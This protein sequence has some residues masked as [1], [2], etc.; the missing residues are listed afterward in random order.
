MEL[1][2]PKEIVAELDKYI[3]G[4]D[5]AKKAVAVALRNRYRRSQLPESLREDI[6]PKNIL[7]KG[8]TGVGKTEIAR[9]LA[10]IVRAPF[11]KVEATKYTE[12]GYVGR[13]VES[14]IRD[15]VETSI[16]LVR[17]EK[18]EQVKATAT[19]NANKKIRDLLFKNNKAR[20]KAKATTSTEKL[21]ENTIEIVVEDAESQNKADELLREVEQGKHDQEYVEVEVIETSKMIEIIPGAP[22]SN[23]SDM[24]DG[25]LPKRKKLRKITV[26]QARRNFVN[27]ESDRLI[28]LDAVNEEGVRR[29]E[30]EGIIFI[31]EIDKIAISRGNGSGPDVSR[32]GV[33]RDILPFVEGCTVNTKYGLIKTD[34]ILFIAAGAFHIAKMDDLIPELQGRFPIRVELENL[35][36]KDFYNILTQPK[37]AITMQ[38]TELLRVDNIDLKFDKDAL[39]EIAKIAELE[40][41]NQENI[42]ARRLHTIMEALLN[43]ISFEAD[44]SYPMSKVVITKDMVQKVLA[45]SVK[46]YDIT[47]YIM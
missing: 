35:T 23:L 3:V 8:P 9:R 5:R 19:N 45:T 4:Q 31:D 37:N 41:E 32:E 36:A 21:D 34:Y 29:A 1:L 7:M 20:A 47:K 2:T 6:T 25:F 46:Q 11:V 14:M 24:L 28:D 22:D 13:D 15:L 26:A 38:Q 44:V 33:Q 27:E 17:D 18:F 40:N 42:G 16:R 12:V 43:D 30:Q 39:Q 10:K